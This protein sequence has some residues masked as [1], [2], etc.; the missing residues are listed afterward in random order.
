MVSLLH[1]CSLHC[2]C[3]EFFNQVLNTQA[4][5]VVATVV[6]MHHHIDNSLPGARPTLIKFK[7]LLQ[8]GTG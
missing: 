6:D 5:A 3:F 4:Y 7:Q 1:M 2:V 8:L